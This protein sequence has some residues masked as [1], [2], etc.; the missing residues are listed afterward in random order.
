MT[1]AI[2][3]FGNSSFFATAAGD[4]FGASNASDAASGG[5]TKM[6]RICRAGKVPFANL[7]WDLYA[8]LPLR[9]CADE[10]F[11]IRSSVIDSI[12]RLE[13]T[14]WAVLVRFSTS[15]LADGG[16]RTPESSSIPEARQLLETAIFFANKQL[17]TSTA[18]ELW[19]DSGRKI[20]YSPGTLIIRPSVSAA[21]AGVISTL[22]SLQ[23]A[24]LLALLWYIYTVPSWTPSL[25]SVAVAQLT[26]GLADEILPAVGRVDDKSLRKLEQV[27]GIVGV[28]QED[29]EIPEKENQAMSASEEA[30]EAAEM[31]IANESSPSPRAEEG[32][33]GTRAAGDRAD[34]LRDESP[35][36][37]EPERMVLA[38][39]AS[40]PIT[41]RTRLQ[42]ESERVSSV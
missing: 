34:S 2:A 18:S 10:Y 3:M 13:D 40:G 41:R 27:D 30:E 42:W 32:S 11:N 35:L 21:A 26:K 29:E 5:L 15:T 23:V 37:N 7:K 38:R 9:S 1:A 28:L 20:W 14:L 39:G 8:V 24:G 12:D 36:T 6:E 31:M 17:L 19:F 16:E 22:I 25:N 4:D 33:D